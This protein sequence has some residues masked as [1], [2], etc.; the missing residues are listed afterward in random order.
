MNDD[1][2]VA[3]ADKKVRTVRSS[4]D[5]PPKTVTTEDD[6]R[7]KIDFVKS[8][9]EKAIRK[10]DKKQK[11]N[12][13]LAF[14]IKILALTLSAIVTVIL[15]LQLQPAQVFNGI[16]LVLAALTGVV[17]GIS[18]FFD[19]HELSIKYKDTVDKLELL[20][21][22]VNYLDLERN[23]KNGSHVDGFKDEYLKILTQTH[24]YFQT[25]R[26][27]EGAQTPKHTDQ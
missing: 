8:E 2:V 10:Y 12:T 4:E 24:E 15:G 16:A 18:A 3:K 17:S 9:I 26:M 23:Y 6:E 20:K 13:K 27:D 5:Q 11:K 7:V 1:I 22:K 14:I 25:V 21:I 19:F